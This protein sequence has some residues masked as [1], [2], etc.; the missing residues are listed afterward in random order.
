MPYGDPPIPEGMVWTDA[1][2]WVP[3]SSPV[4]QREVEQAVARIAAMPQHDHTRLLC[5]ACCANENE[6]K[7]LR[8]ALE[9]IAKLPDAR[10]DEAPTVARNTLN[11]G[12]RP[13]PVANGE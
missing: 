6:I 1:A 10:C 2:G 3:A 13:P 8:A 11:D 5:P 7:R 12:T 9:R 4:W